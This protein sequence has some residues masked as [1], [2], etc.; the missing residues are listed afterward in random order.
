VANQCQFQT[1]LKVVEACAKSG[2]GIGTGMGMAKP[3]RFDGTTS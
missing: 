3:S 1:Q 2:R